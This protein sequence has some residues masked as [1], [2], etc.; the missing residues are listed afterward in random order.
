M[1]KREKKLA[2]P[3]LQHCDKVAYLHTQKC[4]IGGNTVSDLADPVNKT[5]IYRSMLIAISLFWAGWETFYPFS[6]FLI[7][8]KLF[9]VFAQTS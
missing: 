8:A 7:S 6:L 1:P 4:C 5:Q 9:K 2:D 3:F